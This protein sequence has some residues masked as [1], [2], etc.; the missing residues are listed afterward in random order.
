MASS[1]SRMS[2]NRIAASTPT[3][4]TGWTVT[5]ATSSGVRQRVRKS[6]SARTAPVLGQ[7]TPGLA[8]HPYGAALGGLAAGFAQE[9]VTH[10]APGGYPMFRRTRLDPRRSLS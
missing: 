9:Q 10:G 4:R 5:S 1:G 2:A 3:R 8:H 6:T 7:V